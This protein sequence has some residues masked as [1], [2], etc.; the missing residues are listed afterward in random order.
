M[1]SSSLS[2]VFYIDDNGEV[3]EQLPIVIVLFKRVRIITIFYLIDRLPPHPLPLNLYSCN[4][5]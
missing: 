4:L 1:L 3:E 2:H 5:T